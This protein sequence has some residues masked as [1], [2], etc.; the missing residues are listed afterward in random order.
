MK[1]ELWRIFISV[2][3]PVVVANIA[4]LLRSGVVS[5]AV[6]EPRFLVACMQVITRQADRVQR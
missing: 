3:Y 1:Q 5:S 6:R 2:C 4:S